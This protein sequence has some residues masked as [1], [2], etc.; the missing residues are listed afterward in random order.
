MVEKVCV[1]GVRVRVRVRAC[2]RACVRVRQRETE[3]DRERQGKVLP[4]YKL[5]VLKYK[6]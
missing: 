1:C 4:A 3:R 6:T 5:V 2:V